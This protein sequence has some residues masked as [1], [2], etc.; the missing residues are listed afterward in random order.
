[1]PKF[2]QKLIAE[3]VV[4]HLKKLMDENEILL[5]LYYSDGPP[6]DPIVVN[7]ILSKNP[8]NTYNLWIDEDRSMVA[9]TIDENY[10]SIEDALNVLLKAERIVHISELGIKEINENLIFI[11]TKKLMDGLNKADRKIDLNDNTIKHFRNQLKIKLKSI[12]N[13]QEK[14][15]RMIRINNS[16]DSKKNSFH[17]GKIEL[18]ESSIIIKDYND[19]ISAILPNNGTEITTESIDN[20]KF[21]YFEPV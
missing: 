7:V 11:Y 10:N 18:N 14:N 5:K 9:K 12:E 3:N 15:I 13:A 19:N 17:I 20:G 6:Y 2:T 16:S 1:M 21:W 4:Q 8:N